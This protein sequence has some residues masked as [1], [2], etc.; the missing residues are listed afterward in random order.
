MYKGVDGGITE[1]R[2]GRSRPPVALFSSLGTL[3]CHIIWAPPCRTGRPRGRSILVSCT[4]QKRCPCPRG[5]TDRACLRVLAF[6]GRLPLQ[7][8]DS[9]DLVVGRRWAGCSSTGCQAAAAADHRSSAEKEP[10]QEGRRTCCCCHCTVQ[11]AHCIPS[12]PGQVRSLVHCPPRWNP[13][14]H[15]RCHGR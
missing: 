11:R 14:R 10:S 9:P 1:R 2:I 3:S 5:W 4:A 15:S 8:R 7:P 12:S 13:S 6:L